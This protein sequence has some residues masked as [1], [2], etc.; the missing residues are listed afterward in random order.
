MAATAGGLALLKPFALISAAVLVA[1]VF[2]GLA[3]SDCDAVLQPELTIFWVVIP[4]IFLLEGLAL[5]SA[6]VAAAAARVRVH[7]AVLLFNFGFIPASVWAAFALLQRLG[8]G[9]VAGSHLMTLRD[10]FLALACVPH[11]RRVKG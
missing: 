9:S 3:C 10:G 2:P 11:N 1:A 5:P 8:G 6:A 7:G 4:L